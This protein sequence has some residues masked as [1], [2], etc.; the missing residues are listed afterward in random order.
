MLQYLENLAW[1]KYNGTR[2]LQLARLVQ[3]ST[4]NMGYNIWLRFHFDSRVTNSH[5]RLCDPLAP[6]ILFYHV[7]PAQT[8]GIK[9]GS[10]M[11]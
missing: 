3:D 7:T 8:C 5:M 11:G 2:H 9:N 10:H 6:V 1:H 4:G